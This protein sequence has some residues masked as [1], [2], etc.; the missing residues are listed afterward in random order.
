MRRDSR[1]VIFGEGVATSREGLATGETWWQKIRQR[2]SKCRGF[3]IM[4]SPP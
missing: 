1:V 3:T 4:G 2:L